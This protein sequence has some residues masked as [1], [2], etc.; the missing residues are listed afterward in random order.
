MSILPDPEN[1]D[2]PRW[3]SVY[4]TRARL[5]DKPAL[6]ALLVPVP[7]PQQLRPR[8]RHK[9]VAH[10]W[11]PAEQIDYWVFSDARSVACLAIHGLDEKE[12]ALSR[13]LFAE[14]CRHFGHG[15]IGWIEGILRE[16]TDSP[17]T[18]H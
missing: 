17:G 7:D 9:G 13:T 1:D 11:S 5:T 4:L 12:A 16:A 15:R 2:A 18:M 8:L 10:H 14:R 3:V 6:A